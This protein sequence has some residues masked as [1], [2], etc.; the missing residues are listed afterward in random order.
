VILRKR[1]SGPFS[2]VLRE[3]EGGTAVVIGGGLS[4]TLEQVAA[5]RAAHQGGKVRCIAVNDA[6]LWADFADVLYAADS[7]WWE[8]HERGLPKPLLGLSG[9][10]VSNRYRAFA[11]QRCSIEYSGNNITDESVHILRNRKTNYQELSL[12]PCY[13]ATAQGKNSGFQALNLAVLA[14]AKKIVLLAIDG[15]PGHFHGGH[16]RPTP[17]LFWEAMRKAFSAAERAIAD[18]GVYVV[19]SSPGSALDSFPKLPLE[20]ALA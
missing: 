19:N 9:E 3:W 12:D 11:G 18:A 6:Y 8:W 16:P 20:Q 13:L 1:E 17:E 2:E 10:D 5:V 14:G 7:H 15:R 4:L